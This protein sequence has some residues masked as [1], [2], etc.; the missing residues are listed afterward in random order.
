M[1]EVW[2]EVV[3]VVRVVCGEGGVTCLQAQHSFTCNTYIMH[4]DKKQVS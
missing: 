3:R 2:I 4:Q 1:G